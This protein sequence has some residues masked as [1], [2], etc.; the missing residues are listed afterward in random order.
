MPAIM[1]REQHWPIFC[2]ILWCPNANGCR[3]RS[4]DDG[5]FCQ[6]RWGFFPLI[7]VQTSMHS[8]LQ[9]GYAM[10]RQLRFKLALPQTPKETKNNKQQ[11]RSQKLC[12]WL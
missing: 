10:N 8:Q 9:T 11:A 4:V 1:K 7:G 6:L 3:T 2:C 5:Q 12:L